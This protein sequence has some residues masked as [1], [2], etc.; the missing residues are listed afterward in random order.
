MPLVQGSARRELIVRNTSIPQTVW[1][2]LLPQ[3]RRD[4]R[5]SGADGGLRAGGECRNQHNRR[6]DRDDDGLGRSDAEQH[7][8]GHARRSYAEDES[9]GQSHYD[10]RQSLPHYE[11]AHLPCG[12]TE[13][14]AYRELSPSPFDRAGGDTVNSD[15]RER[16]KRII[17]T[18]GNHA[19]LRFRTPW[20][21]V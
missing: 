19:L 8:R 15:A 13:R 11:S 1:R 17:R 16:W 3:R 4:R 5:A 18:N 20:L 12:C 10:R 14:H 2:E 9:D 7:R 21:F 6:H